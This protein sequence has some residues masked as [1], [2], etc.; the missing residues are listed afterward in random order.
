MKTPN[1]LEDVM[2]SWNLRGPSPRIEEQLFGAE[3]RGPNV[4]GRKRAAHHLPWW[5]TLGASAV[6][7]GVVILTLLN[8][9]QLS[10]GGAASGG[11]LSLSNH[12]CAASFA[13]ASAPLNTWRAPILSWT[14]EGASGS[15]AGSFDLLSTNRILP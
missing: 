1:S 6:A 3:T 7:F 4:E 11:W 13:M 15:N 9:A 8:V 14:N 12:S 2:R 10:V 5:Q